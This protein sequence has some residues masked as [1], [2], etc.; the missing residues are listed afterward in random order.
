MKLLC[1]IFVKVNKWKLTLIDK[2]YVL[3]TA[4]R[5]EE[6]NIRM[7][8]ES[9]LSQSILPQRWIIVSDASIDR[10]DEIVRFYAARHRF[11]RFVRTSGYRRR[12]FASKVFAFKVGY[13]QVRDIEYSVIGNL[14]A[15]ITLIPSYYDDIFKRLEA[16]SR[17]GLTGGFIFEEYGSGFVNRPSNSVLSVAG[18]IQ[19]FRRE[20]YEAV[21][22]YIPLE[23]GGEDWYAEV[24]AR[25]NGWHVQ[26]FPE[27]PVFHHRKTGLTPILR[28]NFR[29]GLM[30]FSL[31]SHPLFEVFKCLRRV[32]MMPFLLGALSRFGGFVWAHCRRDGRMVSDE[33]VEFLRSEQMQRVRSVLSNVNSAKSN[34]TINLFKS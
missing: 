24:M 1:S 17:L 27:L 31:G 29:D 33:F 18:A 19:L 8:I 26:S 15:D 6:S 4:A 32:E 3:I 28:R 20:C 12:D 7:A 22:G 5:D 34:P 2:K 9:I 30:D 10:T 11:I 25:M 21:G 23:T 16:S 14:D 13:Q